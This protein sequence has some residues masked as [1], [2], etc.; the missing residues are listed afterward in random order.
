M[1]ADPSSLGSY[2]ALLNALVGLPAADVAVLTT[3][4]LARQRYHRRQSIARTTQVPLNSVSSGPSSAPGPSRRRPPNQ[5]DLHLVSSS[6]PAPAVAR[7]SGRLSQSDRVSRA[8][9]L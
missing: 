9:R 1:P 2:V 4:A 3:L 5:A 8:A 6:T 7:R